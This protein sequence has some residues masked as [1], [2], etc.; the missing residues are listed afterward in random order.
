MAVS[1]LSSLLE[2]SARDSRKG[3]GSWLRPEKLRLSFGDQRGISE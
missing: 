2:S 1:W 3:E